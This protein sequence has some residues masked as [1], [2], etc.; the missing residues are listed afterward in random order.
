M[1]V[2]MRRQQ[3]RETF[4]AAAVHRAP[5]Y[6]S[7]V[8]LMASVDYIQCAPAYT[9]DFATHV[10]GKSILVSNVDRCQ[11]IVEP[12]ANRLVDSR[13]IIKW[14]S[15]LNYCLLFERNCWYSAVK[16]KHFS[17]ENKVQWMDGWDRDF[18]F[19][20]SITG[21][22]LLCLFSSCR[23]LSIVFVCL[24]FP[25]HFARHCAHSKCFVYL[26]KENKK[27]ANVC[28]LVCMRKCLIFYPL[29]RTNT[30]RDSE[31][32]RAA[33]GDNFFALLLPLHSR[34]MLVE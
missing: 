2:M 30:K 14:K 34:L 26:Q 31:A 27:E 8:S 3:R 22:C 9:R 16:H 12:F 29:L 21:C 28:S 32:E 13:K 19:F 6:H 11:L 4:F 23:R 7:S 33:E 18:L 25:T 17:R 5:H 15:A 10:K 1:R 24:F 20:F